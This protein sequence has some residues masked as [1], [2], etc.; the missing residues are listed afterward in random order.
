MP[1]SETL[2]KAVMATAQIMGTDLAEDAARMFVS[3]LSEYQEPLVLQALTRCRREVKSRLTLADVVARI[4]DGRPGPNEAWAM[5]PRTERETVVWTDE[6]GVASSAA[7][8]LLEAGDQ[9][10]A[11]M[12]F[13]EAYNREVTV[14]RA[15]RK[16]VKWTASLG[17]DKAGRE[18]VLREAVEKGRLSAPQALLLLPNG[19]FEETE[20]VPRLGASASVKQL[21]DS[22]MP[23]KPAD[24]R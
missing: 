15:E 3:D 20:P 12:A 11:R 23:A 24:G 7:E 2:V 6:M 13:I 22:A 16:P 4:E 14:A 19:T 8:P 10:A 5:L 9:V 1:A 18:P 21:V 17:W